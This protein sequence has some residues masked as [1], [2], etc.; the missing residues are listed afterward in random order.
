MECLC[1]CGTFRVLQSV[2]ATCGHSIDN[3]EPLFG[4]AVSGLVDLDHLKRNNGGEPDD[5]L[6]LTKP[7]GLGLLTTAEKRG[8]LLPADVGKATAVMVALN[9]VGVSLGALTGVHALTDITGFGLLG[10]LSELCLGAGLGAELDPGSIPHVTDL[11]PYLAA[12]TIPG[13]TSRNA[14][15]YGE[16]VGPMTEAEAAVLHDP[17]TSGGLLIAAAPESAAEVAEVL[18]SAG[19]EA[20]LRPIGRLTEGP[21]RIRVGTGTSLE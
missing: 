11:T 13:G 16:L 18:R 5:L 12:G 4:L 9:R 8:A 1:K 2:R 19:L 15:S 20:H 10:H 3:P 21:T 17:Q 6:W 14:A 7:L